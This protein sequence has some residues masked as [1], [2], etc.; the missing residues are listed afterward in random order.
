MRFKRAWKDLSQVIETLDKMES[1]GIGRRYEMIYITERA[2]RIRNE[3]GSYVLGCLAYVLI[4]PR[5]WSR[6]TKF[7]G[8]YTK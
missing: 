3:K 1:R 5:R 2:K 6:A 8:M 4:H 7:I